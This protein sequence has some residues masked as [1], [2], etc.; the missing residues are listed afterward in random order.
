MTLCFNFRGRSLYR[1]AEN[2]LA[3]PAVSFMLRVL[4]SD[5]ALHRNAVP[6]TIARPAVVA[7]IE[8]LTAI[9]DS[10]NVVELLVSTLGLNLSLVLAIRLLIRQPYSRQTIRRWEVFRNL[11]D[12][13]ELVFLNNNVISSEKL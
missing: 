4:F 7:C 2:V 5:A 6:R 1:R 8:Y 10:S 9:Y 12:T 13:G 3:L 11:E